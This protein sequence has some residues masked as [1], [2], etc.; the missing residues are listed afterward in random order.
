VIKYD[1]PELSSG[2][3]VIYNTLGREIER[4]ARGPFEEGTHSIW[5]DGRDSLGR[6]IPSGIY[7]LHLTTPE[8]S[9][10]IKMLLLK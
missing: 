3:L 4:I 10:T 5:W 7:L 8:Y 9:Q 1:I 2:R 6:D